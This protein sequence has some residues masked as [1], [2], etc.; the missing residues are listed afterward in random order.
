MHSA[1]PT[2]FPSQMQTLLQCFPRRNPRCM[3]WVLD[4][5]RML[6]LHARGTSFCPV[7]FED[8]PKAAAD[9][10]NHGDIHIRYRHGSFAPSCAQRTCACV[11]YGLF[12]CLILFCNPSKPLAPH[13]NPHITSLNFA[14]YVPATTRQPG[15]ALAQSVGDMGASACLGTAGQEVY[16]DGPPSV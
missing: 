2:S 16:K 1:C 4:L 6:H 8:S 15:Q 10:K 3:W 9:R 5:T 7:R 14:V 11:G 12:L 13:S